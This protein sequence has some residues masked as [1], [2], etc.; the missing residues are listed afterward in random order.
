M[1]AEILGVL[2]ARVAG[3]PLS[4]F[5]RQR[6]FEPLG[7]NNTG[8][9]VLEA[10]LDR[11][12]TCYKTDFST[13][14]I[15]VLEEA[16]SDLLARPCVFEGDAANRALPAVFTDLG[17]SDVFSE[18]VIFL[19]GRSPVMHRLPQRYRNQ[20]KERVRESISRMK[21]DLVEYQR[22][23]ESEFQRRRRRHS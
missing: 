12:A 8:F 23:L 9:T 21:R 4:A 20:Y 16:R 19:E 3:M 10:Q 14:E 13:G 15:T 18:L 5:M 1:S 22:L 2:I 11:V 7:M 17:L 6:I